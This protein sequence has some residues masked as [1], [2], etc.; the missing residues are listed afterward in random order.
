MEL[1][2]IG[3]KLTAKNTTELIHMGIKKDSLFAELSLAPLSLNDSRASWL[4]NMAALELCT[5][6]NFQDEDS[7]VCSYLLL[8]AMF[9]DREEDVHEL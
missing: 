6:L 7:A 3:I 1:S 5:T 9:V 2:E 4:V 8:F